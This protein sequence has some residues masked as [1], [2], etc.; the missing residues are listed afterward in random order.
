ML[1]N[2]FRKIDNSVSFGR[3]FLSFSYG[4]GELAKEIALLRLFGSL[5]L[6]ALQQRQEWE[7]SP[8]SESNC[9]RMKV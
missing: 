4:L 1:K 6:A 3:H 5:A 7:F 9:N 8:A 2:P